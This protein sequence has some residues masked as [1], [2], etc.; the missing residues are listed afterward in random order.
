MIEQLN[1]YIQD[2][3]N[4]EYNFNL[5]LEYD[6]I[7]HTASAISYY[8][9]ASER[10][11]DLELS[12]TSLLRMGLCFEIQGNR[13]QTVKGIYQQAIGVLPKRPEAYYLLSRYYE[14]TSQYN[15]S[16][17]MAEIALSNCQFD[18]S[19]LIVDV[20]YLG[21]YGLL[22]EKA[23]SSW[24]WGK[25]VECKS[26]FEYLYKNYFNEMSDTDKNIVLDNMNKLG[27]VTENY[28]ELEYKKACET[29]SD[30]SENLPILFELA[31]EC[32]HV[33]EMGV[34]T[35]VSTRAFLNTDVILRSY[36]LYIDDEVNSLF[37]KAKEFDKDVSYTKADVLNIEI[38]ETD[39]LFIDT[40]HCYDQLKQELAIHPK[41]VKKY[42]AFHDTH[43]FGVKGENYSITTD[44]GYKE[45]PLGLLPAIIEFLIE[46]PEW[47]F[48]IHKTNN[49]GLS[50]IERV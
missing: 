28:F 12:Y 48:K 43:T 21:K 33:T 39:L 6:N 41:K 1:K 9:R 26:L 7:G 32:S 50:V 16:Y 13:D 36:D 42:I 46:N 11:C 38:E 10:S 37:S 24:W 31:K 8:L 5:A 17:T 22:L 18:L 15:E 4:S 23:I 3:E 25:K 30:I 45:D 34:R 29:F 20:Q 2:T 19:P 35:G 40:W 44:N 47:K 27:I 49:N 14:R